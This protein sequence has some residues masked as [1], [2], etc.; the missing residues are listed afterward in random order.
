[1]YKIFTIKINN[2]KTRKDRF[3]PGFLSELVKGLEPP[4]C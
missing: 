4:T 1:M 2:K 3:L